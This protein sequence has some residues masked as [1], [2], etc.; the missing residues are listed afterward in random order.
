MPVTVFAPACVGNVGPGFDVL[1]L[2]LEG[3]GDTVTL[4]LVDGPTEVVEVT[5]EDA[6]AVPREAERNAAAIAAAAVLHRTGDGRG[7]R[8]RLRKGVPVAAGLGGS[9]ASSVAGALAAFLALGRDP[10]P[11]E[12]MTAALEGETA[13]AG[14]HLDNIAGC[15]LGGLVLVRATE[16]PD[17]VRVPLARPV[18]VALCTPAARLETRAARA[19]LPAQWG[20]EDWVQ[21]MANTA[22]LLFGLSTGD[23]ALVGRALDDRFAE[24]RRAPLVPR[25]AEMKSAA[26]DA[27]ALGASISGAGPTV[28]ALAADRGTAECCA[29]AMGRAR[30][31]GEGATHVVAVAEKGARRV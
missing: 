31:P 19:V 9:A 20:R 17:A 2:A 7:A 16:P 25:F 1:G 28:F 27:G 30:G 29:Q 21:Q 11:G 10:H 24:P 4:E 13:V 14:R 23:F 12:V 5:G 15:V 3:L 8:L 18:W 26:L 22:G 6:A